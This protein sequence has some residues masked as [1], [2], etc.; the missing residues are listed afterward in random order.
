MACIVAL[1]GLYL[2]YIVAGAFDVAGWQFYTS[3][4]LVDLCF[5]YIISMVNTTK[6]KKRYMSCVMAISISVSL[7]SAIIIYVYQYY[8]LTAFNYLAFNVDYLYTALSLALSVLLVIISIAPKGLLN[9]IND[10]FWPDNL[11]DIYSCNI[12]DCDRHSKKG[13]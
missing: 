2:S 6:F 10:R 3:L 5:L 9:A 11:S 1:F 7:L 8:D 4:T 13:L 12:V